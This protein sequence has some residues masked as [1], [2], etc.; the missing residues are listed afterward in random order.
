MLSTVQIVFSQ[1]Y[2]DLVPSTCEN[3]LRLCNTTRGG[4]GG[5]P[6]H[7]IVK[8]NWIQCGG[9]GLKNNPNLDCENFIVPHDRRGVLAMANDGKFVRDDRYLFKRTSSPDE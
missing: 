7:R 9:Y 4:Y 1:L 3:F 5:T 6:I 8:D 2:S